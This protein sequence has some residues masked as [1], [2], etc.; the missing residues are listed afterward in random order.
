[1]ISLQRRGVEADRMVVDL[2]REG[3]LGCEEVDQVTPWANV[4]QPTAKER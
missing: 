4:K 3:E 2:P 1:M